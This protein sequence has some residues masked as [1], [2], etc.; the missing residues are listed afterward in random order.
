MWEIAFA[1]GKRP[2]TELCVWGTYGTRRSL[3]RGKVWCKVARG[4]DG[5][6][7][8]QRLR[9]CFHH[10]DKMGLH[11]RGSHMKSQDLEGYYLQ[12]SGTQLGDPDSYVLA[13]NSRF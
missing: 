4:P 11:P 9:L 10:C 3:Q 5:I 8:N 7:E 12:V 6:L 2:W 13:R 1:L